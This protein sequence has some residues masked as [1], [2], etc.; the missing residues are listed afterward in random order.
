SEAGRVVALA[1]ELAAAVELAD[2]T[3]AA[4]KAPQ[5][6][7]RGLP[8]LEL[9]GVLE[10]DDVA[11]VD[12]VLPV[13]VDLVDGAEAGQQHVADAGA[14]HPE[15]ALTGEERVADSLEGGVDVD[16]GIGCEPA[17]ALHDEAPGLEPVLDDVSE[18]PGADDDLL[19]RRL[20][21]EVVEEE[22]L[23]GDQPLEAGHD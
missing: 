20:G 19:I 21:G 3:L 9:E 16:V 1:V 6:T 10:G 22:I 12:D 17:R 11:G 23:A 2:Q 13:D 8:D 4:E 7:G 18:Q 5:Q 15:D 14:L